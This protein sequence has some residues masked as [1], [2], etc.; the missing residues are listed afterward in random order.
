MQATEWM[1]AA[2]AAECLKVERRTLLQW[3]RQGKTRAF[4]LSGTVRHVWRFKQSDLD[5]MLA[6]S[7]A[8]SADGRQQLEFSDTHRGPSASTKDAGPGITCGMRPASAGQ[9]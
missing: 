6:P 2:E 7:S 3:V 5:A 9:N 4:Q 8:G 1:T